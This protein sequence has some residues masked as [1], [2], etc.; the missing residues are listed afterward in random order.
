MEI[1][2]EDKDEIEERK[3]NL[4]VFG[5]PQHTAESPDTPW[6]SEEKIKYDTKI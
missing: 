1:I 6:S 5:L 2:V 3:Y 4:V